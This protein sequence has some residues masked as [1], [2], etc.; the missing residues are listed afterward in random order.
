MEHLRPF[1]SAEHPYPNDG[2]FRPQTLMGTFNIV[3]A[4]V[5]NSRA[6]DD[7]RI[8]TNNAETLGERLSTDILKTAASEVA[9]PQSMRQLTEGVSK[10][11][12]GIQR[13]REDY[14][15]SI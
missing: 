14:G 10:A 1:R 7:P 5:A 6:S 2:L 3:C 8:Y 4:Y 12:A 13:V 9:A 11:A 15:L